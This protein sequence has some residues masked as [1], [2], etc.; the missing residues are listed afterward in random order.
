LLGK[1]PR[2]DIKI[3]LSRLFREFKEAYSDATPVSRTDVR[4]AHRFLIRFPTIAAG[5]FVVLLL[6]GLAV[7]FGL[8]RAQDSF[9]RW[10]GATIFWTCGVYVLVCSIGGFREK[11]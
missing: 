6:A 5:L 9:F 2:K 8:L 3:F 1:R 10:S 11:R 7:A 4:Y